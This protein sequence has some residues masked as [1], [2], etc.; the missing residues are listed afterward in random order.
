MASPEVG[1]DAGVGAVGA[2]MDLR[3]GTAGVG[4]EAEFTA[5][6]GPV[7]GG[8]DVGVFDDG[9]GLAL[10]GVAGGEERGEVVDGGEIAG[11]DGLEGAAAGG[12]GVAGG[13]EL[14]RGGAGEEIF[15]LRIDVTAGDVFMQGVGAEVVQ[16]DDSGDDAGEGGG[17]LRVLHVGDVRGAVDAE[18]VDGGVQRG[19]DAA[20]G[21]GEVDDQA[22]GGD[23]VDGE[24][25]GGEP[26]GDLG[27]VV[28]GGTELLLK[29]RGREPLMEVGRGFAVELIDE[30]FE[31]LFLLGGALELKQHVIEGEA[32]GDGAAVVVRRWRRN[33]RCQGSR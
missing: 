29:L 26:L 17:N 5:E 24:A 23:L 30:E 12:E 25:A 1:V 27:D 9:D 20:G 16:R 2:G 6:G 28:G 11:D 15:R 33:G 21:A 7:G 18:V 31:L 4:G 32:V 14:C 8:V 19:A 10:S 3:E 22:A 13:G